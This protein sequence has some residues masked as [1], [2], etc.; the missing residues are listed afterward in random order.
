M[1]V[2]F[3]TRRCGVCSIFDCS[4][5]PNFHRP[6]LQWQCH[7]SFVLPPVGRAARAPVPSFSSYTPFRILSPL[8]TATKVVVYTGS[9][10]DSRRQTLL[11]DLFFDT[12][13]NLPPLSGSG[14]P[15]IWFS[16]N[17]LVYSQVFFFLLL[18]VR[19]P[20][21][22]AFFANPSSGLG[23]GLGFEALG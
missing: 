16:L 14:F 6:L 9:P 12:T 20:M 2:S 5:I 10:G 18:L 23:F 19:T 8:S 7:V 3:L 1:P 17:S 15:E 13:R 22:W 11:F 4:S 21:F